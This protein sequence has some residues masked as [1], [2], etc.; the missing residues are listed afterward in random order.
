MQGLVS[1]FDAD[2]HTGGLCVVPKSHLLHRL[3]LEHCPSDRDHV[4]FNDGPRGPYPGFDELPQL[5]VACNAG[6]L[7]L[8]DSRTF[9]CNTPA[10]ATPR[11][12]QGEL[13]RAVAYVCM[14]PSAKMTSCPTAANGD[15]PYDP[16]E[17]GGLPLCCVV[18]QR[19]AGYEGRWTTTHWP[20]EFGPKYGGCETGQKYAVQSRLE[21]ASAPP[22]RRQLIDGLSS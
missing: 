4:R 9:H 1:L 15:Q 11:D 8:W 7:V 2:E 20:H 5:L 21:I 19:R 17:I 16:T 12:T 22:A 3:V 10:L 13:L 6:D 18:H 14:T